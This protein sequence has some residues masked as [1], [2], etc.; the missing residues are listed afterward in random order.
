MGG[1]CCWGGVGKHL[2]TGRGREGLC[3]V[4]RFNFTLLLYSTSIRLF[5]LVS[6]LAH[7]INNFTCCILKFIWASRP[8]LAFASSH[9]SVANAIPLFLFF[10]SISCI[11]IARS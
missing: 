6:D 9:T 7:S 10:N 2:R 4:P 8:V 5:I 11:Q 3:L 1:L